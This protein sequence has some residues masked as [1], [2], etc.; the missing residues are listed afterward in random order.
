MKLC[1]SQQEVEG[2]VS[3]L[4]KLADA[5]SS[6]GTKHGFADLQAQRLSFFSEYIICAK[7]HLVHCT[8]TLGFEAPR[9]VTFTFQKPRIR[10]AAR[11]GGGRRGVCN[12]KP[13]MNMKMN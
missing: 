11:R 12:R 1:Q 6:W 4:R 8:W 9:S 2:A 13:G 5:G 3:S 10:A 7:A